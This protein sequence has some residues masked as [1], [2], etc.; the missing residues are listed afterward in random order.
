MRW[1]PRGTNRSS[2]TATLRLG[3]DDWA[4]IWLNGRPVSSLRHDDGVKAADVPIALEK[5]ENH[6][7]IRLSNSD[8]TEWRC[9]AFSCVVDDAR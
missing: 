4:K 1:A 8:N 6:L 9:W 7:V 3:F 5:G 2:S